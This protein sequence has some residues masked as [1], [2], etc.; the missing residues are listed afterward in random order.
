MKA[1]YSILTFCLMMTLFLSLP[2]PAFAQ[3]KQ[4]TSEPAPKIQSGSPEMKTELEGAKKA[5]EAGQIDEAIRMLNKAAEMNKGNC[6]ECYQII[7]QVSFQLGD[8][9]QAATALRK[10][11]ALK[12]ENEIGLTNML[13]VALYLQDDK[14]ALDES[15]TTFK[16]VIDMVGDKYPK[17]YYNLGFALIKSG[18]EKEGVEAL[19]KYVA[20]EPNSSQASQAK[21][22]IANPKLAGEKLAIDFKVKTYAG[23]ELSLSS[24]KGKVV[25]L[26]FWATWCGPCIVEMPAVKATWQKY[27]NDNFV[28]VGVSLDNSKKAFETYIKKEG[29]TWVQYFDGAGWDN[30]IAR[31]YSVHSIPQTV[32]IDHQGVIRAVGLRGQQLYKKIGDLINQVKQDK[33]ADTR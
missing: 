23:D 3:D 10:A 19:K 9:A 16:R 7:G 15:I 6:L 27:Q 18:K 14:K 21:T 1:A 28:I 29:I 12:P 24:L 30:K 31:L 13:G 22:V 5:L 11:I 17:A 26:D 25:L 20:I 4:K 2:D 33:S 32:L 8:Y